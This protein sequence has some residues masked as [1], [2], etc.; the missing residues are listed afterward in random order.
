MELSDILHS[1][2]FSVVENGTR[3]ELPVL[4][5]M[6]AAV[7]ASSPGAAAALI[8]WDSSEVSRLRAFGV[9]HGLILYD[10]P[11]CDRAELLTALLDLHRLVLVA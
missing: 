3:A 11:E 1:T 7:A 6:A 9:V 10:I 8:D 5:A 2:A 4:D